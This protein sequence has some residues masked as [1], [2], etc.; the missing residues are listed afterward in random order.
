MPPGVH[1]DK[2]AD[3]YAGRSSSSGPSGPAR[4]PTSYHPDCIMQSE[5]PRRVRAERRTRKRSRDIDPVLREAPPPPSACRCYR[6]ADLLIH[7]EPWR[8]GYAPP[9]GE[10]RPEGLPL[11][12]SA[13]QWRHYTRRALFVHVANIYPIFTNYEVTSPRGAS[14]VSFARTETSFECQPLYESGSLGR[15]YEAFYRRVMSRTSDTYD[16]LAAQEG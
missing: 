5:C 4:S 13:T 12:E 9:A 2:R 8:R 16:S 11:H 7:T 3:R 6:R 15:F 10:D 1:R 14:R